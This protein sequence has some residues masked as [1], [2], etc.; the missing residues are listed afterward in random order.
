[1]I[2]IAVDAMGGDNAPR[3]IVEGTL[4]ALRDNPDMNV[5]LFGKTEE[6][7]PLLSGAGEERA[8][9]ELR[10]AREIITMDEAPVMAVRRKTGSS[11]VMAVDA[12]KSGEAQAVVSA[13]S[14]GALLAGGLF[15][16][17]RVKGIDRPAIATLIPSPQK[18][19]I[20]LDSGANAD[21][22]PE[23]LVGFA[24][25]GSVYMQQVMGCEN[26]RVALVNIGAESEKGNELSKAAYKLLSNSG[27]NF[28]G[29]IEARDIPAGAA[30]V[31]VTD[32]FTGNVILKLIEGLSKTLFKMIK[33]ELIASPI[34]KLGA[35]LAKPAF[36]SV[37]G[38]LDSSEVGGAPLLGTK[39]VVIKA[40]GSSNARA[41][42]NALLQ[43]RRVVEG[44]V[45][46]IIERKM[47][48][49]TAAGAEAEQQ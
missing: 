35:L 24:I 33:T 9:L 13:G 49:L 1:M 15:R 40:H 34:T 5:L 22:R 37:K 16:I 25:M 14:T 46:G 28:T 44:D 45:A 21:C 6:V 17:G 48:E 47:A 26:P 41:V 10:D 2:R 8:R 12:V 11:L 23:Y 3:A 19:Y 4:L 7:E 20:L 36:A 30:D 42:Q 32:G 38:R 27:L 43:A 29:N 39:G 18:P 31:V